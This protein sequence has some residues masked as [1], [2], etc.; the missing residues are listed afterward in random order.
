M[1]VLFSLRRAK[2]LYGSNPASGGF[3]WSEF[4][5]L[6]YRKAAFL[7]GQGI[8]KGDRLAVWML[9]SHE[10]LELYFATAIAGIVIVPINTRWHVKDV[11]FTLADA[12]AKALFVDQHFGSKVGEL[13][14]APPVLTS[15]A[16][17]GNFSFE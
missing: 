3:T 15:C 9:N 11:D 2:Q 12:G 7:R 13:R 1:N 17:G 16:E 6:V 4:Y 10:Y 8:E 14:H 5:D